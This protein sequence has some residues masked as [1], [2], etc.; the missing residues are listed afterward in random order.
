ML[1]FRL[2]CLIRIFCFLPVFRIFFFFFKCTANF[3]QKIPVPYLHIK[4]ISF[5]SSCFMTFFGWI[6]M[7]WSDPDPIKKVRIRPESYPQHWLLLL[8]YYSSSSC[9]IGTTTWR[10]QQRQMKRP[11]DNN[12]SSSRL[13]QRWWGDGR[14]RPPRRPPGCGALISGEPLGFRELLVRMLGS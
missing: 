12:N 7:I 3:F 5:F 14:R 6:R 8:L 1:N 4:L 11:A 2:F 10:R 9:F 13:Q